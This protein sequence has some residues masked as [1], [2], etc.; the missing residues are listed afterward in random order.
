MSENLCKTLPLDVV[1]PQTFPA[2]ELNELPTLS[3]EPVLEGPADTLI[4]SREETA[5]RSKTCPPPLSDSSFPYQA[6]TRKANLLNG[7][8][9]Y[10]PLVMVENRGTVARDHLSSERTFLAYVRTSL[11]L[12]TMGVALVQLFSDVDL[13]FARTQITLSMTSGTTRKVLKFAAP[14]GVTS[15]MF[16]LTVLMIG[17]SCFSIRRAAQDC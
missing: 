14:L 15:I 11:L 16:S 4:I 17:V 9:L 3:L 6:H 5:L 13:T 1:S 2:V 10:S 8:K 7:P 12:T